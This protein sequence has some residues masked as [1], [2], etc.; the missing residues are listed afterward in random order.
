MNAGVSWLSPFFLLPTQSR[1]I[2]H[3]MLLP[4]LGAGFPISHSSV[5]TPSQSKIR[6]KRLIKLH[7]ALWEWVNF[8]V[9]AVRHPGKDSWASFGSEFRIFFFLSWWAWGSRLHRNYSQEADNDVVAQPASFLYSQHPS[10][11]SGN[12]CKARHPASVYRIKIIPYRHG[13]R[14]IGSR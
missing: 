9:A 11:G 10:Q 6:W 2:A 14:L 3:E 4:T 12:T 7:L 1:I 5:E 13:R 8:T